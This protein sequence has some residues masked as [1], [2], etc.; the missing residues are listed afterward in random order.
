MNGFCS[1][2]LTVESDLTAYPCDF[3][4]LDEYKLGTVGVD[5]LDEILGGEAA[6]AFIRESLRVPA[7]CEGCQY[8][9]LCR[10]GCR[11]DRL[12]ANDGAIGLNYYC[13]AYKHFFARCGEKMTSIITQPARSI[14][15]RS[16]ER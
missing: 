5:S 6:K 16:P 1:V 2:Q 14:Q 8:R 15:A 3:Y 9:P 11:R 10:N 13:E 12:I 4:A 7:E